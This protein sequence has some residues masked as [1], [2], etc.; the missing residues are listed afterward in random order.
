MDQIILSLKIEGFTS[1]E[2]EKYEEILYALVRSGGLSGVKGGQTIIH[3]DGEGQFQ[4][5][6]LN[7]W[8]WRKRKK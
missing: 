2:T 1:E 4:G 8:P 3:F 5:I 6:Q 7:Y